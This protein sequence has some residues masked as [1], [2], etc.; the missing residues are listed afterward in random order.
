LDM[1]WYRREGDEDEDEDGDGDG[2]GDV[3]TKI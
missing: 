3:G 2:D 1:V